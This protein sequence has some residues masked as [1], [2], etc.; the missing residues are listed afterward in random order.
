MPSERLPYLREVV[1]RFA[2]FDLRPVEQRP[3]RY[4]FRVRMLD[5][6]AVVSG[7]TTGIAAHRSRSLLADGDDNLVFTTNRSGFSL[8]S[9]VGQECRL[10]AGCAALLSSTEPGAQVFPGSVT[11]LTLRIPYRRLAGLVGRPDDALIRPIPASNGPLRLLIDY[12]E[13]GLRGHQL[14]SPALKQVFATHVYDLVAL[15]IG[16]TRDAAEMARGRGLRVARLNAAKHDVADHLDA[17]ALNVTDVAARLGVT[18]RYLQR[19]FESEGTTF[20]E[21]VTGERLA[22]AYRMLSDPRF[23]DRTVTRIAFDVG[24]GN[25]SYFNRVFRRLYG[26]TPSDVQAGARAILPDRG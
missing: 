13:M 7:E 9:Q 26:A 15:A 8:V 22:R 11:H 20:S 21:H 18:P 12:V 19:L 25:L 4:A 2:R 17:E 10:D 23:L 3:L 6:L 24:F 5:G 16:A 1:G 14:A